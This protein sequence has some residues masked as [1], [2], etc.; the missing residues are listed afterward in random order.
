MKKL[1]FSSTTSMILNRSSDSLSAKAI[2]RKIPIM[3][4]KIIGVISVANKNDFFF[5][6]ARYSL[7][8]TNRILC[9]IAF[10]YFLNKNIAYGGHDFFK[11]DHFPVVHQSPK[12]LIRCSSI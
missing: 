4:G 7:L 12:Y 3:A 9:M 1:L 2:H 10:F 5:T 8:I 11:P 6:L